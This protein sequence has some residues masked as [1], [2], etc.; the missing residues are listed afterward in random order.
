MKTT[1]IVKRYQELY[2]ETL[3]K[4]EHFNKVYCTEFNN[5]DPKIYNMLNN[6]FAVGDSE[7]VI[8]NKVGPCH[9]GISTI[10][11][12]NIT[13][14]NHF[15]YLSIIIHEIESR[16]YELLIEQLNGIGDRKIE[17]DDIKI[18][19]EDSCITVTDHKSIRNFIED[20]TT[21]EQLNIYYNTFKPV[22]P[23]N[24]V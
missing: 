19:F 24:E 18:T 23:V 4:I 3:V 2:N 12:K 1:S 6:N 8:F 13:L 7:Y 17:F 9:S 20:L 15:N 21:E 11:M 16:I 10:E 5:S 14:Q 22:T